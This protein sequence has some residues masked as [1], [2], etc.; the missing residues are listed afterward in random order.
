MGYSI[1][2]ETHERIERYR[3]EGRLCQ[4]SPRCSQRATRFAI[5][6]LEDTDGDDSTW[7]WSIFTVCKRH[8]DEMTHWPAFVNGAMLALRPIFRDDDAKA[9]VEY[10]Q[11]RPVTDMNI[12]EAK[13]RMVADEARRRALEASRNR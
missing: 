8:A 5:C 11:A 6:L 3:A 12:L 10:L 4:G 9:L 2:Q 13:R 7:R 1:S